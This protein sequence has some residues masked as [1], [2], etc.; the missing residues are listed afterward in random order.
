[1][2]R[3]DTAIFK[4]DLMLI[5]RG[6]VTIQSND[7]IA[8]RTYWQNYFGIH[9]AIGR[10]ARIHHVEGT[11]GG[12]TRHLDRNIHLTADTLGAVIR[13]YQRDAGWQCSSWRK[14][15]GGL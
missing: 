6:L 15:G 4:P 3:L 2:I 14:C 13:R 9:F 12:A 11:S 7:V 8:K 10:V 1:M 5:R